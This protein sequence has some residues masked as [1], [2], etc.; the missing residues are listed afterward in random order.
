MT[1][2]GA[3]RGIH[4]AVMA[5]LSALENVPAEPQLA[6]RSGVMMH[7]EGLSP[8]EAGILQALSGKVQKISAGSKAGTSGCY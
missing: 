8:A 7:L 1:S 4:D 3:E 2:D 5:A 6:W